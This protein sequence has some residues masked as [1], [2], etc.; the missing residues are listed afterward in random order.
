[1]SIRLVATIA[2]ALFLGLVAV[3][4]L[5]ATI[6][7]RHKTEVA[8]GAAGTTPVVVAAT[9]I[10]RGATLQPT[11]LKVVS[12]PNAAMPPGAFSTVGQ[13][14]GAQANQRLAMRSLA[15]GEPVLLNA[16]TGPGGRLT[17][18]SVIS[19][20]MQAVSLRTTDVTGVGG[21]VL[22]GDRVDVLLTRTLQQGGDNP[23]SVT[24]IVAENVRVL[25]VDQTDTDENDKPVVVK[26]V[27][28]EVTP[29]Q[30]QTI[31][32]GQTVGTVSLTLRHVADEALQPQ[33]ATTVAELGFAVR[34]RPAPAPKRPAAEDGAHAP[35]YGP[36]VVRVT[37]VTEVTPYRLGGR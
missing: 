25:G 34:P 1:M 30:A 9:P 4:I 33:K 2:V 10:A 26:A 21:Y 19:P 29:G 31:T 14:T 7:G 37:R 22:P 32:L 8:A 18:A 3:L 17:L 28:V 5:N 20:G 35:L 24:Q 6:G 11:M 15:P 27:T 23:F 16:V 36:G 13:L 12:F